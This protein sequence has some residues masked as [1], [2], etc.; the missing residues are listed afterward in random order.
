MISSY[1]LHDVLYHGTAASS[2]MLIGG[3]LPYNLAA[4]VRGPLMGCV[5]GG[6]GAERAVLAGAA[7]LGWTMLGHTEVRHAWFE[8]LCG[9]NPIHGMYCVGPG[10]R[11]CCPCWSCSLGM[12]HAGSHKDEA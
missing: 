9:L 2:V 12:D 1:T 6:L 4:A 8:L 7:A 10:C 3:V 5:V 11:A